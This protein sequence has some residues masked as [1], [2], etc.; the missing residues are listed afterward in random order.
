MVSSQTS[1]GLQKHQTTSFS[2]TSRQWHEYC[3]LAFHK[4]HYLLLSHYKLTPQFTA[5]MRVS[6]TDWS[7]VVAY[8]AYSG[9]RSEFKM[10]IFHV[11]KQ[12]KLHVPQFHSSSTRH[13][14]KVVLSLQTL[15]PH[16]TYRKWLVLWNRKGLVCETSIVDTDSLSNILVSTFT[17][18]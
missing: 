6:K 11:F 18:A 9:T 13:S 12:L 17:Q 2:A 1:I 7:A 10:T 4:V 5:L 16:A 15:T 14:R 8:S 3:I